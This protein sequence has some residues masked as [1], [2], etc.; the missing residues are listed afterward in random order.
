MHAIR[1]DSSKLRTEPGSVCDIIQNKLDSLKIPVSCTIRRLPVGNCPNAIACCPDC[2]TEIDYLVFQ[3]SEE[4][5]S[6]F[7]HTVTV[8]AIDVDY[9]NYDESWSD[10]T[11]SPFIGAVI[12]FDYVIDLIKT[13]KPRLIGE[14]T[15][16]TYENIPCDIYKYVLNIALVCQ[17]DPIAFRHNVIALNRFAELFTEL[18]ELKDGS[19]PM[20]ETLSHL[21]NDVYTYYWG[22]EYSILNK[23]N[24]NDIIEILNEISEYVAK[25]NIIGRPRIM[26]EDFAKR[27]Y[28]Q[29]YF[30]G[31]FRGIVLIPDWPSDLDDYSVLRIAHVPDYIYKD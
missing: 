17:D 13:K 21:Y 7:V 6:F 10:Y 3:S 9:M 15:N 30:N 27:I 20:F 25:S 1:I 28:N 11:E 16:P 31:A 22:N 2:A 26:Y 24:I 19:Q 14:Q 4:G 12:D 5:Y 8:S 18:G 29:K 23:Y